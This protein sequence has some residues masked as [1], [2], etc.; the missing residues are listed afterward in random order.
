MSLSLI[1]AI[2]RHSTL[3]YLSLTR[4]G[5]FFT[6]SPIIS[7]LRTTARLR[8]SSPSND[9]RSRPMLVRRRYSA[10]SR[11]CSRYSRADRFIF[12]FAKDVR[13]DVR[14]E[15]FGRQQVNF[16]AEQIF[17]EEGERHEVVE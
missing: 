4:S 6:A 11:M 17:E 14:A 5:M 3:G 10:S 12:Y 8:V 13:P 7:T 9:S 2:A 15:R 1:P 16:P